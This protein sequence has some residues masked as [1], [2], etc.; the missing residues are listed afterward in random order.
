MAVICTAFVHETTRFMA[1]AVF[2]GETMYHLP[3]TLGRS[4]ASL[5]YNASPYYIINTNMHWHSF[6][7]NKWS[8]TS[9]LNALFTQ[10]FAAFICNKKLSLYEYITE[11][12]IFTLDH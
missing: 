9:A 12:H 1:L 6:V 10:I 5:E 11:L 8:L 4:R 2:R 7:L 3:R